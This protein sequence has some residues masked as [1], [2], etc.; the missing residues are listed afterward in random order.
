MSQTTTTSELNADTVAKRIADNL[1]APSL[2]V[3]AQ[4]TGNT[5][6]IVRDAG[7]EAPRLDEYLT[8]ERDPF[9]VW[10]AKSS[11]GREYLIAVAS[12][13]LVLT[14]VPVKDGDAA[15]TTSESTATSTA[16]QEATGNFARIVLGDAA[17]IHF[18]SDCFP[19]TIVRIDRWKSGPLLGLPRR[20]VV[21]IDDAT[22]VDSNG[23]SDHQQYTYTRNPEGLTYTAHYSEK[24]KCWRASGSPIVF[25]TRRRYHD[26][27]F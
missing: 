20:V 22:R 14:S 21:Q 4:A 6:R 13:H 15:T 24:L 17:T 11:Y 23:M 18:G 3:H 8:V 10:I 16:Q 26:Y 25:G 7:D 2:G 27:T 9:G 1:R 19:A 12:D 5:V